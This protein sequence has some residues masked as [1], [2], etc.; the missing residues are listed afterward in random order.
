VLLIVV[1]VDGDFYA[2]DENYYGDN[3]DQQEHYEQGK[4]NMG[5]SLLSYS[6]FN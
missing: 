4:Y 6:L 5:D 2:G 3:P 1:R